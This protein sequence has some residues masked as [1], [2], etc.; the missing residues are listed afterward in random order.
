MS[1]LSTRIS[2]YQMNYYLQ[3]HVSKT[4]LALQR[5]GQELS[6]GRRADMFGD[7]GA[8]AGEAIKMRAREEDTQ[9]YLSANSVLEHKLEAML[10]AIETIR[11][12]VEEVL[13]A[14]VIN[15]E[16]PNTGA[17]AVQSQARAALETVIGT[18]NVSFN[19]EFLFSGTTSNVAATNRWTSADVNTGLSPEDV[20]AAVIG[21]GPVDVATAGTIIAEIDQ[22]FSSTHANSNYNFEETF[23]NGTPQLDAFG[24]PNDRIAGRLDQG[25]EMIYGVQA[26]DQGF[27]DVIKGLS[28][29]A[30]V[31][32]ESIG[33]E[34]SY[35]VWMDEV[36]DSLASGVQGV[37]DASANLG[38][39]QQLVE[40]AK[41]RLEDIS[42]VQRKQIVTYENIDPYQVA[43]EMSSL[44]TQLQASYSVSSRLAGLTILDWYR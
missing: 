21:A 39:N 35:R 18:L 3:G 16:S 29:L 28:M 15:K 17:F 36:V 40:N 41:E 6:T 31:D 20:M 11:E 5:A 4:S 42:I 23:Y 33:D 19:G 32:I 8:R 30:A 25:Q 44:E 22:V 9:A 1:W 37:L 2:S 7:L 27:R 43:T 13:Q 34:A 14:A 38:F 12:P 10:S 24:I 26:N